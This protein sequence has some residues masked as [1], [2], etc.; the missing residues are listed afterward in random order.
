[1][2]ADSRASRP[3]PQTAG[4]EPSTPPAALLQAAFRQLED[5]VVFADTDVGIDAG[6]RAEGDAGAAAGRL[7]IRFANPALETLTGIALD[8]ARGRDLLP[9]IQTGE[10]SPVVSAR[11]GRLLRE[12]RPGSLVIHRPRSPQDTETALETELE[13]RLVPLGDDAGGSWVVRLRDITPQWL[14]DQQLRHRRAELEEAVRQ[15]TAELE[16]SHETLRLS[17]RLATIGTLAAGL[18]HDMSNLLMPI[19]GFLAA[20]DG[21]DLDEERRG[22]I[23]AARE[24]VEYLQQLADNLWLFMI[25]SQ[26]SGEE[27]AVTVLEEWWSHLQPLLSRAVPPGIRFEVDLP[28]TV[29]PLAIAAHRLTQAVLN[30]LINAG[31]ALEGEGHIRLWARPAEEPGYALVGVT[32]D[33]PGMPPEVRKHAFEPFFTTKT[34]KRSTG[35]G[36]WLV[37]GVA[38]SAGGSAEILT[39]PGAGATVLLRLPGSGERAGRPAGDSHPRGRAVVTV[40]DRRLH[41]CLVTLLEA[42]GYTVDRSPEPVPAAASLWITDPTEHALEAARRLA[43]GPRRRIIVFGDCGE[44]WRRLGALPLDPATSLSGIRDLLAHLG[45]TAGPTAGID[46]EGEPQ[47]GEVRRG[48]P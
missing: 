35:L 31:D 38:Q 15:R 34:R 24:A 13:M 5:A 48:E 12:R 41:A 23:P 47:R 44:K 22:Q 19:R 3:I 37:H 1:M 2:P 45:A 36:L 14:E 33:G 29:P 28:G 46:R 10:P 42:A 7:W 8:D 32:D 20:V 18:A 30:L 16:S 27:G 11:L 17:E 39:E 9:L 43:G 25:E 26:E 21:G 6:S 4:S 40:E